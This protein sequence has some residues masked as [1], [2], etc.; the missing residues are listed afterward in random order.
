MLGSRLFI[1]PGMTQSE[2]SAQG[3][4]WT[5]GR[6]GHLEDRNVPQ[7]GLRGQDAGSK[8]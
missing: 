4:S 7:C 3:G 5:L 6:L 8:V 1:L 2:I